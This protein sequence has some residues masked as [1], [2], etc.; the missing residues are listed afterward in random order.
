MKEY[1]YLIIGN[2]AAGIS[3]INKLWQLD[4]TA[5]I[6]CISEEQEQPYNKCFLADY[7]SG[8]KEQTQLF[9]KLLHKNAQFSFGKRV[10]SIEREAKIITLSDNA[11]IR[12][13]TLLLA[14]G[15]SPILPPIPGRECEGVFTFHTLQDTNR[16]LSYVK[17]TDFA[18]VTI[19]GGGLS[20]LEAADALRSQ[21]LEVTLVEQ[22]GQ[23]LK[24]SVD[25]E[26]A[27]FIQERMLAKGISFMPDTQVKTIM[28]SNGRVCGVTLSNG[29]QLP[30]D[31]VI[32]ATGL[33]PNSE[34]ARD[35]QLQ[36]VKDSVWVN[37]NM[38]TSDEQI[39][40]AGDL[41]VVRDQLTEQLIRSCTWPDAMHQGM[42]AAHAMAGD[43]K[44]YPGVMVVTSS[45]F[46]DVKFAACGYG[47][48]LLKGDGITEVSCNVNPDEYCKLFIKDGIPIGFIM[49]GQSMPQLGALRRSVLL[50]QPYDLK[51]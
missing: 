16:I 40:A 49:I 4:P 45:A 29:M 51:P 39:Y 19:I 10:V 30:T 6:L 5:S 2:S 50:R 46:F 8:Q 3:A 24:G 12:Y 31:V 42:I 22:N 44:P 35:A 36:L 37:Q 15:S 33:K 13:G 38:Q 23:V 7:L 48:H 32:C 27:A 11:R 47:S 34:L 26:A 1:T 14:T 21:N 43:A 20:G 17:R 9:T 28:N 41:V 18:H 25:P